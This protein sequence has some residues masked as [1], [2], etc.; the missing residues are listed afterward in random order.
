MV[1]AAA[2]LDVTRTFSLTL[3]YPIRYAN[4]WSSQNNLSYLETRVKNTIAGSKFE[5]SQQTLT[6]NSTQS[7]DFPRDYSAEINLNYNGPTINSMFGT[8]IF[9]GFFSINIGCQKKISDKWGTL[10]I[11]IN[12]LLDSIKWRVVTDFPE[13]SLHTDNTFDMGNRTFFLT[14]S[15]NFGNKQIKSARERS[16]GAEDE[17]KR[18]N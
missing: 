4:W 15:R 6:V 18:V 2:N 13:S 11:K 12:D 8:S 7:F 17:K 9:K 1:F 3:G 14:Y 5:L 10:G 16:T